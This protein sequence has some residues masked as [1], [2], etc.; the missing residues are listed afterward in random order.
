L[1]RG[2]SRP[3]PVPDRGEDGVEERPE[4]AAMTD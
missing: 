4:W 2:S 3:G 1:E